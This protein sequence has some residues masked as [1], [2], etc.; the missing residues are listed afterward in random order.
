MSTFDDNPEGYI[1][2]EHI[3]GLEEVK[4][5]LGISHDHY[6][7]W[8]YLFFENKGFN[9]EQ[10]YEKLKRR[11]KMEKTELANYDI[12]EEMHQNMQLGTVMQIGC[13]KRG[14][15]AFYITTKREFPQKSQREWKKK[16]YDRWL[17][18]GARLV[19]SNNLSCRMVWL[20]NQ[21]DASLW[22]NTDVPFQ[23]EMFL[24]ISKF[25]PGVVARVYVCNM[26]TTLNAVARTLVGRL[27]AYLSRRVMFLNANEVKEGR[28]LEYFDKSSLPVPLGGVIEDSPSRW[29]EFERN[30]SQH[31]TLLQKAIRSGI[32]VKDLEYEMLT[33][34]TTAS[35][36]PRTPA[37]SPTN[38]PADQQRTLTPVPDFI[39]EAKLKSAATGVVF[40]KEISDTFA[41]MQRNDIYCAI[42]RIRSLHTAASQLLGNAQP[43]FGS[44][45][46]QW[47]KSFGVQ[48]CRALASCVPPAFL[49]R[50]LR[51]IA[52]ALTF[53]PSLRNGLEL[54]MEEVAAQS[55]AVSDTNHAAALS[56]LREAC[57]GCC[58]ADRLP[59]TIRTRYISFVQQLADRADAC[60]ADA[61]AC[62]LELTVRYAIQ[63]TWQDLMA[64]EANN[65]SSTVSASVVLESLHDVIMEADAQYLK[66]VKEAQFDELCVVVLSQ[67]VEK[68]PTAA[69]PDA[70]ELED[71]FSSPLASLVA[72]L[73][74]NAKETWSHSAAGAFLS[75]QKEHPAC[76][77]LPVDVNV[78]TLSCSLSSLPC[79]AEREK[80]QRLEQFGAWKNN[81]QSAASRIAT[82][83]KSSSLLPSL[84]TMYR[85][86]DRLFAES[87]H[88]RALT[89]AT[90]AASREGKPLADVLEEMKQKLL[91]ATAASLI[92]AEQRVMSAE[93][94]KFLL[95]QKYK[96]TTLYSQFVQDTFQM[97]L[98]VDSRKADWLSTQEASEMIRVC[99]TQ[100]M[101]E[102]SASMARSNTL[103]PFPP[104]FITSS[105][106]SRFDDVRQ[107]FMAV[108]QTCQGSM[109]Y[110]ESALQFACMILKKFAEADAEPTEIEDDEMCDD[111]GQDCVD[112]T[113]EANKRAYSE[114][115]AGTKARSAT[116]EMREAKLRL[117]E[118]QSEV[119][120][121]V[122]TAALQTADLELAQNQ[123]KEAILRARRPATAVE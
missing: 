15:P 83:Q 76:R 52:F 94:Q 33:H 95:G 20:V 123:V 12:T 109:Q 56:E 61:A 119:E 53:A 10:T 98:L 70:D 104:Y 1:P 46:A 113:D 64:E 117:R 120:A 87:K 84:R 85:I 47:A 37:V 122:T 68:N 71:M 44:D 101:N 29:Q 72:E 55:G 34:E 32:S 110:V 27:P 77:P 80:W 26:S 41:A 4:R 36:V 121:L 54:S 116:A 108:A 58:A 81:P 91:G 19:R 50:L 48:S 111:E 100:L 69:I 59:E 97:Q 114:M 63:E 45:A 14:R 40:Q 105:G 57:V 39:Q 82:A 3:A 31:F 65:F 89:A 106:E 92:E 22:S 90:T 88:Y 51:T 79:A 107:R 96:Q 62:S 11:E 30:L 24:R 42:E 67:L 7:A 118:L 66:A 75:K 28:L 17:A 49:P 43:L 9:V 74:Q 99:F 38:P 73:L 93:M 86:V 102:S 16:N 21:Q 112:R 60:E 6:D 35:Q 5:R 18:Y 78:L 23:A 25:C 8:L 115:I 13:D 2:P 103:L